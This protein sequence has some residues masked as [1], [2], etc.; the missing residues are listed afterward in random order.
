MPS[1]WEQIILDL[2]DPSGTPDSAGRPSVDPFD[3]Q[4]LMAQLGREVAG[5]LS[6]AAERVAALTASGRITR[7]DLRALRDEIESARRTAIMAQRVSRL[8]SGRV[9]VAHERLD[10]TALVREAVRE[11]AREIE[12]RGIELRQ[13]LAPAEVRSDATLLFALLQCLL[14]WSFEHARGRIDLTLDITSWPARAQ[15]HSGFVYRAADEPAAREA[16]PP[17]GNDEALDTLSW[18]LLQQ[19]AAVL[20]IRVR[21]QDAHGT[22]ELTLEF[23]ATLAPTLYAPQRGV[24]EYTVPVAPDRQPLAGYQVL[25][26]AAQ[27]EVRSLVHQALLPMGM[28]LDFVATVEEARKYCEGGL[29]HALV[30]EAGLASESFERLRVALLV[31]AP[32]LAFIRIAEQGRA[33]EVLS[34]G[35]HPLACVGREAIL[36]TLPEALAFELA[37]TG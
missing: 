2:S 1:G 20:G 8:V 17:I 21:R 5:P 9:S 23:P 16:S 24:G 36:D 33:F 25:A 14:D 7:G 4:T 31:E 29:P 30:Y 34:V 28:M 10:L 35:G 26:L 22:T 12:G 3:P 27:R 18:L 11:R 19:T 6:S 13:L 32:R 15:L 37:R